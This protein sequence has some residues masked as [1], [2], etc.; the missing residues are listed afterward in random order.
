MNEQIAKDFAKTMKDYY[1]KHVSC[2]CENGVFT[3]VV[4]SKKMLIN[5]ITD[6]SRAMNIS[7]RKIETRNARIENGK[8]KIDAIFC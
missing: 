4:T 5:I 3:F 6:L 7:G 8:Y 2:N 1:K